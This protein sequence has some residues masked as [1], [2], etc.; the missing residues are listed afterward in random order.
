MKVFGKFNLPSST[1]CRLMKVKLEGF[2]K[3]RNNT[4][5]D[6][7]E[8]DT[9]PY[10]CDTTGLWI[11]VPHSVLDLLRSKRFNLAEAIHAAQ[12][13]FLNQFPLSEDLKTECK[14]AEKEYRVTE[15]SRKR[16]ARQLFHLTLG[17]VTTSDGSFQAHIL[18]FYWQRWRC[19]G[20]S[21]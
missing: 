16:P 1:R 2:F 17:S 15:S 20:K 6:A 19:G 9:P 5:L 4:I 12:H 11:D 21:F 8:I 7:I 14:A 13:A 10:V 3:I 18:R